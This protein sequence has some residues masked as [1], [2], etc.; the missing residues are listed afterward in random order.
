MAEEFI[1]RDQNIL[2]DYHL[3]LK[4]S[5]T[6]CGTEFVM[7]EYMKYL[8]ESEN[9][10]S[11][12]AG[13]LGPGCSETARPLAAVAQHYHTV[14]VSYSADVFNLPPNSTSFF[15]TIPSLTQMG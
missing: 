8:V 6:K 10:Q 11:P 1:N 2:S 4:I 3:T 5:D 13:I 12:I 9:S 14:I 7:K 15:R